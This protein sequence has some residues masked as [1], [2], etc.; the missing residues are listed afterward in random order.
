MSLSFKNDRISL[1]SM[2]NA[3]GLATESA[4][5][6]MMCREREE[7]RRIEGK[8][9]EREPDSPGIVINFR[10]VLRHFLAMIVTKKENRW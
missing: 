9:G 4:H 3:L 2:K 5:F 10:T 1:F 8:E 7:S 6:G